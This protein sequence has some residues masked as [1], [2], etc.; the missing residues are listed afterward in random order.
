MTALEKK[1]QSVEKMLG[2]LSNLKDEVATRCFN[3]M[4]VGVQTFLLM[5]VRDQYKSFPMKGS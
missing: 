3:C 5:D 1:Q 4:Q 2:K